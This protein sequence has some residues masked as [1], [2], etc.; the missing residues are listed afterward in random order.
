M[1]TPNTGIPYV[2]EN[3][4]D[5]AAGLNLALNTIDALLQTAVIDMSL[6]APPGSPSDGD[7]HIVASGATGAW[8]GQDNNLARY[9]AEGD[10]WQFYEAGTNVHIVLN[11]DDGG[12]YA[13]TGS[14]W[15]PAVAG[16]G[17]GT[18]TSVDVSAD[19]S[20]ADVFDTSGGPVTSSGSVSIT[21]VDAGADRIVFWDDSESKLRYLEVGSNLSITGT[22]LNATGG[23][24]G[25]PDAP[26]DGKLY[27][28]K[29]GD[30]EEV[31]GGGGGA[32]PVVT[33]TGTSRTIDPDT[34]A[35]A[36]LRFTNGSAKTVTFDSAEG[37]SVGQE[38]HIT[39]RAVSGNLTLT[40]AGTMTLNPP[41][42]GSLVLEPGDTVTVKMVSTDEADVMGSTEA[43]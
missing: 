25:I 38:F 27:G 23:G 32:A 33:V 29:D 13:W 36:Y 35:G 31:T 24:G 1:S 17:S 34:D 21:A 16:A 8:A 20:I 11:R 40:V 42:G 10:F 3:T 12:L 4:Q 15:A 26:S 18:V 9:V 22:V 19:T 7:L 6:T 14:T 5:P 30:W 39:N 41:K 2:P 43:V 28:R 37:F